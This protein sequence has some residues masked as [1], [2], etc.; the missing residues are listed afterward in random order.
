MPQSFP[1]SGFRVAWFLALVPILLLRPGGPALAAGP[2]G[3]APQALVFARE[4]AAGWARAGTDSFAV[5]WRMRSR[6]LEHVRVQQYWRG[7]PVLGGELAVARDGEG[8]VVSALGR[9]VPRPD[10]RGRVTLDPAEARAAAVRAGARRSGADPGTATLA[11]RPDGGAGHLV[12]RIEYRGD[13][14]RE[15]DAVEV[16]AATGAVGAVELARAPAVGLAYAMDPRD[17]L[18]ERELPGL[19]GDGSA[20]REPWMLAREDDGSFLVRPDGDFR[21]WPDPAP[22]RSGFDEVNAFVHARDFL[23]GFLGGL[24]YAGPPDT[25]QV[26]VHVP[27]I[28]GPAF[29]VDHYVFLGDGVAGFS[30]DAAKATDV[31]A[32]EVMH[33]VTNGYGVRSSGASRE[34]PALHEAV[35]DYMAAAFTGDPAIGE[36]VYLAYPQG[37]TRV[38]APAATFQY[39]NFDDVAYG[40]GGKGSQWANSM[41]LSGALWDLRGAIG[42]S[43]DSLVLEALPFLP[44]TPVWA[45][46]AEAL[47]VADRVHHG[48]AG[49]DA[50]VRALSGRGIH[51]GAS[52]AITGPA[53]LAPGVPGRFAATPASGAVEWSVRHFCGSDWCAEWTALG[54]ADTLSYADTLDFQLRATRTSEWGQV[55]VGVALVTVHPPVVTVIGPEWALPRRAAFFEADA[56]GVPPLRV[57]WWSKPAD[58]LGWRALGTDLGQ[59]ALGNRPFDVRV[60]VTDGI[61]RSVSASRRVQIL[62]A[63]IAGPVRG[64]GRG[65]ALSYTVVGDSLDSA[66]RFAWDERPICGASYC[67]PAW[68]PLDTLRSI[69]VR[70]TLDF[71]LRLRVSR[72]AGGG[73]SGSL[74]VRDSVQ[75]D[76]LTPS[77]GIR[78]PV[79]GAAGAPLTLEAVSVAEE[80]WTAIWL[81]APAGTDQPFAFTAAGRRVTLLPDGPLDV[82][83][84][85]KDPQGRSAVAS[86][87]V[88][89]VHVRVAGPTAALPGRS[90]RWSAVPDTSVVGIGFEWSVRPWCGEG[91]CPGAPELRAYGP[92]VDLA[93]NTDFELLL[94]ATFPDSFRIRDSVL[95]G[96]QPPTVKVVPLDPV[97]SGPRRFFARRTGL[98]APSVRWYLAPGLRGDTIRFVGTGDTLRVSDPPPYRLRVVVID[99]LGRT[100][101][102]GLEVSADGGAPPLVT[103]PRL[104]VETPARGTVD[105]RVGLPFEAPARVVLYDV[106][107]R[108]RTTLWRGTAGPVSLSIRARPP[109]LPAGLY[110]ARLEWPGGSRVARVSLLP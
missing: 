105:F 91:P 64:A 67:G 103:R 79:W 4:T 90:Q 84:R 28:T 40:P 44:S 73:T 39:A 24:G 55:I 9:F 27:G 58:S 25:V 45:D 31:I 102:A 33:A 108:P 100:A 22:D 78:G 72:A 47:L 1:C 71:V 5:S 38:D 101:D 12:W 82:Q 96:V 106:A 14:M 50:I 23:R 2:P 29:T 83:L 42:S 16:D 93:R 107:G 75:V 60:D 48:S 7:L 109:G 41:I 3:P 104:E 6:G 61:G 18:R 35:S 15:V 99:E 20:L 62:R 26:K 68:I 57:Q 46:L 76:V 94:T 88:R 89:G 43:A 86:T 54:T 95:V 49:H 85:V 30:L 32:H 8:R 97:V 66:M 53:Q 77:A 34:T 59:L 36:W 87:R 13:P 110:F 11:V 52:L 37:G 56:A 21:V 74:E 70:E 63:A 98:G 10:P 51:G 19:S 80:P 92:V 65:A 69:V 17:S 81:T